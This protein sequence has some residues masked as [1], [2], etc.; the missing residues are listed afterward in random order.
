M[1]AQ[2][3]SFLQVKQG[4][5]G[6]G[7]LSACSLSGSVFV[8]V[9]FMYSVWLCFSSWFLLFVCSLIHFLSL[10]LVPSGPHTHLSIIFP[11]FSFCAKLNGTIILYTIYES[12]PIKPN[13]DLNRHSHTLP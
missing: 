1:E 11:P 9:S 3:V 4:I 6:I 2:Y 10:Y 13:P 8:C 12:V 5:Q 7:T